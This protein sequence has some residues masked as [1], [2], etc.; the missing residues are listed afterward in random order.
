MSLPQQVKVRKNRLHTQANIEGLRSRVRRTHGA[1]NTLILGKDM[2]EQGL[3]QP[4]RLGPGM[5][6]QVGE[7]GNR[8]SCYCPCKGQ[9]LTILLSYIHRTGLKH[10]AQYRGNGQGRRCIDTLRLAY[11]TQIVHQVHGGKITRSCRTKIY[12]ADLLVLYELTS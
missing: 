9:D 7:K 1:A 10:V 5:D 3:S 6:E 4:A 11:L 12:H 2:R 8:T